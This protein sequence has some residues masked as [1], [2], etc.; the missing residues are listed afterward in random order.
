MRRGLVERVLGAGVLCGVFDVACHSLFGHI[1][2][3]EC[4]DESVSVERPHRF[5][6]LHS[7]NLQVAFEK[8]KVIPRSDIKVLACVDV[9]VTHVL[10]V[11]DRGFGS[12]SGVG[13]GR[14]WWGDGVFAADGEEDGASDGGGFPAWI[15]E[16][17]VEGE[18]GGYVVGEGWLKVGRYE[19]TV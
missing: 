5:T 6:R 19:L 17:D 1:R 9:K 4:N 15:V 8:V 18:P 7:S 14:S 2:G 12:L 16:G 11:F 13:E 3:L 10:V